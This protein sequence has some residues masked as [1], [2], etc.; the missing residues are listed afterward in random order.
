FV[1][2]SRRRHTIFS[3]DWSSD[4]CSSDLGDVS[5]TDGGAE[6]ARQRP[7]VRDVALI[8]GVVELAPDDVDGMPHA[9][10]ADEAVEEREEHPAR[11]DRK[12]VVKGKRAARV[13]DQLLTRH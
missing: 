6:G 1:F 5:E 4:V 3:R 9:T 2:S 10:Y 7:K 11:R 8:V 12:R 13:C